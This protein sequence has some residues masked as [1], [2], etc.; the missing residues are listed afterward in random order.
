[1]RHALNSSIRMG[2]WMRHVLFILGSVPLLT[3]LSF[4]LLQYVSSES[5]QDETGLCGAPG[6]EGFLDSTI[7]CEFQRAD[8]E[9]LL[10]QWSRKGMDLKTGDG[11]PRNGSAALEQGP[12]STS[13]CAVTLSLSSLRCQHSSYQRNPTW[14]YV[15]GTRELTGKDDLRSD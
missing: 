8:S 14:G 2:L 12:G 13:G 15:K 3:F 1:M 4:P 7:C 10:M 9:L 6:L 11:Q 5:A